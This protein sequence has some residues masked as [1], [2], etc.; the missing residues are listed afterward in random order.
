MVGKCLLPFPLNLSLSL[1]GTSTV[2]LTS[3]CCKET[4]SCFSVAISSGLTSVHSCV[5]VRRP[6]TFRLESCHLPR[7]DAFSGQLPAFVAEQESVR[8][9]VYLATGYLSLLLMLLLCHTWTW[10]D[11]TWTMALAGGHRE[12]LVTGFRIAQ[13]LQVLNSSNVIQHIQSI[14][15]FIVFRVSHIKNVIKNQGKHH[16]IH[17][18]FI[19]TLYLAAR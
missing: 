3:L 16:S 15:G 13:E 10:P 14:V 18:V 6:W 12:R 11:D 2:G 5:S 19:I 8:M 4:Y 17:K 1:E 9:A 7:W